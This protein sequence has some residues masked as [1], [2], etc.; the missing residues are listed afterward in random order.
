MLSVN[1][2]P[3]HPSLENAFVN[4]V[5]ALKKDDPLAPLAV[6]APTNWML[7]RLQERLVLEQDDSPDLRRTGMGFMNISFMNF[8]VFANE[9]CRRSGAEVGQIVRQPVVYEYLIA[10][11]LRQHT[12]SESIFKNVQ[13]LPALARSLYQVIQDL[14]DANVH[15]DDLK[16][17]VK[18][19]FVE[20]AE[21]QKLSGVINLYDLFTQKLKGINISN[22]ADVY[23]LAASCVQDSKFLKNFKYILAYG[24]YDLTGVEQDFF[25]EIFRHLPTTLFIPYRKK[26][27]SFAYVKPFFESFVLGM[28]R[29]VEELPENDS[30]GFSC[31]MDSQSEDAPAA[32]SELQVTGQ[33]LNTPLPTSNTQHTTYNS[34]LISNMCII[35]ASGK[36][37]EVWTVA[38]EILK[39]T[40]AGYKMDEIGVVART[41]EP[42]ADAI[43]KIFQENY[44]PFTTSVHEP[45]ERY[46]LIK[47][48]R[49]IL[50]LKREDYY[51]PMVIE[52]LGSPYFKMPAFDHKEITPRPDLWDILSRRLGI[53]GDIECWLSRLEQA[54][55]MTEGTRCSDNNEANVSK[56][57]IKEDENTP[58]IPPLRRGGKRGGKDLISGGEGG[59]IVDEEE[60]GRYVHIPLNQVEFLEITLC[61]LSTDL[62]SLPEK[63]SWEAMSS[64]I[65]RF[66]QSY[67]TIPSE[68]MNPEDQKR[69]Q[70]IMNKI[71]EL[72][73]TLCTLDCLNEEV[74][75]DQFVDTFLDACK[76][77]VL[78]VGME[79][80][81]GVRVLDAMTAR[82]IPCRALFILGLN[83]KVFPR[84]ISEEPFMRDHVRRKLSETLG[85]FIPEKLRG[86]EEERLLFYFLLNAARERLYLLYERSDEA[87]KP[88]I[89]SHYLMD[90]LQKVKN[91]SA[92]L[93]GHDQKTLLTSPFAREKVI[94]Y[95]SLIPPFARGDTGGCKETSQICPH[96]KGEKKRGD[97]REKSEYGVYVP[98]GIKDKLCGKEISLL[99]PKE[100]GIRMAL[101]KIDPVSFMTSFGI[102]P[103]IFARSQTALSFMESYDQ[104][105]TAYDGVIG[106]M[107]AWW[108]GRACRG[109][110]PTALETFGVC[111]F[112]YF[113]GEVLELESLEEPEKIDVIA[114]VDLGSLY[115]A[116]L[117]DFYGHL[118]EKGYFHKKTKEIKPIELLHDIAKKY[119]TDIERKIPIPYP[120]LWENKKEEILDYLTKFVTWDLE[121]IEQTGYI[122]AYLERKAHLRA[123]DDLVELLSVSPKQGEASELTFKGKIDRIDLKLVP[124]SLKEGAVENVVRFRV[125]DYKSGRPLKDKP[126]KYAVRG[127][128]LQLPFYIVMAERILSEE[129]KKGRISQG[130]VS[131]EDA[132][133]VYV[134]QEMEDKKGQKGVQEKTITGDEWKGHQGQCWETVKEFLSYIRDGIFPISPIE[135]TQK[136]EWCEFVTTCRKGHQPQK[137]RLEQDVRLNKYREISNLNVSKKSNKA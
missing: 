116:I 45:L 1:I 4:T 80:G 86:F 52:L 133:F 137:F 44:I 87:G 108:E 92:L 59:F 122:P 124:V 25:G 41:L 130:Q 13:S 102:N 79:N 34:N 62:S 14:A 129:I 61:K 89:Q 9:I 91:I 31:L 11:L 50:L 28:A 117:K 64:S 27:P 21:V 56:A 77:E 115:H 58:P 15:I 85:N 82:G 110:S 109:L 127:Q 63:A 70:F 42:Y 84:A 68:G 48:I 46:P 24:F 120:I 10:G 23:H 121:R 111:P 67:I 38:K 17:A 55:S 7:N 73:H 123:Q 30:H 103:D 53:R 49:Q 69:D 95:P 107:S 134:A 51:R 36:R 90:V 128:K 72:H 33:E 131:L 78:P 114:A 57:V 19:G 98:R 94:D 29:D 83:E 12:F 71:E 26:H 65:A 8:Y 93:H 37:D 2:G 47:V 75:Q 5:Q 16:E 100:V 60:S 39:L 99:T 101:D 112:K 118:I 43:S 106:D 105:L 136:C 132:S 66:L 22:D 35:N 125:V 74:A 126:M 119:F 76:R 97:F 6:V 32:D 40:E 135:D 81:R 88:K 3:Y 113:M 104:P 96:E 20:G 54:K 18:E